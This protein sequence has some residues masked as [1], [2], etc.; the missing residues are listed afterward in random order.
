MRRIFLP[1]IF[2]AMIGLHSQAQNRES[3]KKD[4]LEVLRLKKMLP[5]KHDTSRVLVLNKLAEA[6]LNRDGYNVRQKADSGSAFAKEANTEATLINYKRGVAQSLINLCHASSFYYFYNRSNKVD[7]SL[8]FAKWAS[9]LDQLFKLAPEVND[10]GI[11]ALAF[12]WQ[13]DNLRKKNDINGSLT[14]LKNALKGFENTG[15]EQRISEVCTYIC[16]TY[17]E[18][19]DLDKGFDYCNKALAIARKLTADSA[20]DQLNASLLQMDLL[21]MS[22]MYKTAGDY[23]AALAFLRESRGFHEQ[24]HSG[25]TW[26]MEGELGD[27]FLAQKNLDSA[28]YYIIPLA[29]SLNVGFASF[30]WPKVGDI[31]FLRSNYDSASLYYNRAIDTLKSRSMIE[32]PKIALMRSY[33]GKAKI[34]QLNHRYSEALNN[35]RKSLQYAKEIRNVEY[36]LNNYDLLAELFHRVNT[37]DSAYLYSRKYIRLKDSVLSARFYFRLNSYRK[38]AEDEKRIGQINLLHKQNQLTQSK[39]KQE[40]FLRNG[41][42]AGLLLLLVIAGISVRTLHLRRKNEMLKRR[43]VEDDL[44][45]QQLQS[46]ELEMQ[47]L[48]AQMNPHFIFNCLSSINRFILKNE[49]RAASNYLTRFSRLMR[50]VL[51]NSQRKSITLEDELQMVRLY[52]EMERLRFKNSF[53][54]SITFLNEIEADNISIPPLILQPFCENAIWHGLMHKNDHGLLSIDLNVQAGFLTCIITDNGVGRKKAEAV[55]S[56]NVERQK[57]FGLQITNERLAL[58]NR[59]KQ[60]PASYQIEDLEDDDGKAAGTRVIVKISLAVMSAQAV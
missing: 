45:I 40:A 20:S 58:L 38:A 18:L 13:A 51:Q 14:A 27:I 36:S 31:Y 3:I 56:K 9:Y 43:Q 41:L 53:D 32:G 22:D 12:Y 39:L 26:G 34:A 60:L 47:A 7:N 11:W 19:G 23:D 30:Q 2:T 15:E 29:H 24:H 55:K 50:M 46:V 44:R 1:L 59:N 8:N 33:Y 52:L 6:F 57:S 5:S 17:C 16:S 42:A 21:N 48:R 37:N 10:A 54:Y 35:S 4:S 25:G 28:Y 49:A